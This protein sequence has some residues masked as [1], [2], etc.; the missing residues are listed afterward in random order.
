M[1]QQPDM[2]YIKRLAEEYKRSKD[3]LEAM[4]KRHNDMKK[5]LS[6]FVDTLG[7]EDDKGHRWLKVGDMELKRERRVSRSFNASAAE[8]W[9]KENN[10]WDSVKEVIE[11]VSEEKILGLAWSNKE[12]SDTVSEF[13]T[14]KET[15]AFKV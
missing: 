12:L 7:F 13:Y 3:G 9:A 4:E 14:E 6:N 10:H 15:W 1:S 5:E 11:V 2:E 8:T